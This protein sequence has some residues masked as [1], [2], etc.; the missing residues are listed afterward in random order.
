MKK[1][2]LLCACVI[3]VVSADWQRVIGPSDAPVAPKKEVIKSDTNGL[4]I[5]TEVFGFNTYDTLIDNKTF[6]RVD[7][8]EE[9]FDND[10]IRAGKPQIPYIRLLI[11]VPDSCGFNVSIDPEI[12]GHFGDYLL[13]PIPRIIYEDSGGCICASEVY[14]YDTA[15]YQRDT[16]YP[17][18]F[19]EVK[20]A[21]HWR[22]QRV[23][24]IVLYPVQFNPQTKEMYFYPTMNLRI[25]Y[26]GS[27]SFNTNGLGPFEDMGREVLL[28]YPGIDRS[29]P[30]PPPPAVHYYTYL[31]NPDNVADYIIV[32]HEAFLFN[33]T[34][35][36]WIHDFAQWRVDHNRFDVGI[37]TM[38]DVYEEFLEP[39]YDDSAYA[40]RKFLK[41]AY[42]NWQAYTAL[43]GHFAYSLFIGDWDYVPAKLA[44]YDMG[45][46]DWLGAY[47]GYFRDFDVP[48]DYWD[49]IMLGRWPVKPTSDLVTI[50]QKTINYE[51]YPNIGDWRRRGLL[52]AGDGQGMS[53]F[54][55][56]VSGSRQF[57]SDINYDTMTVRYSQINNPVAF[58]Q[59]IQ[60]NINSGD[61]LTVYYDH[62]APEAWW[63]DFD[64][65]Y[66]KPLKNDGRL[67]VVLSFACL[68]AMFQWDR[69][70][71]TTNPN[72]PPSISIAEHFL[73][74]PNGGSIAFYGSTTFTGG[75]SLFFG[76]VC[77]TRLLRNQYWILGKVVLGGVFAS[78]LSTYNLY[79]YCLLGDPALDL[80]DFTA[81]PTMPDLL[82]RPTGIDVSL[83][84]PHPYITTDDLIPIQVSVWNIGAVTASNIDVKIRVK[85]PLISDTAVITTLNISQIKARDSVTVQYMWDPTIYHLENGVTIVLPDGFVGNAGPA[86]FIFVVDP[87][88]TIN[89]SWEGNNRAKCSK[90]LYFY[91]YDANWPKKMAGA[92]VFGLGNLD[93]TGSVEIVAHDL[94]KVYVFDKN[95]NIMSGWPQDFP[96]V[97]GGVI[98]D[99][100]NDH[101]LD[102]VVVS[103]DSIKAYSYQGN[104]LWRHSL[105]SQPYTP[106]AMPALGKISSSGTMNIIHFVGTTPQAKVMVYD[107][108]G[109]PLYEFN[110]SEYEGVEFKSMGPCISDVN[111][112]GINEIVVSY[113]CKKLDPP[114]AHVY[115]TEVFN[116]IQ[117]TP[118][119]T[120]D[121]G[122]S[123]M[124]PALAD[125]SGD[126]YPEI[127]VGGSDS[128]MHCYKA[129]TGQVL[130]EELTEGPINSSPA[131]GDIH[132]VL[133]G[134]EVAFANNAG[135]QHLL[136]SIN[137]D[138]VDPW[139]YSYGAQPFWL[140]SAPSA[141]IGDINNDRNLDIVIGSNNSQLYGFNYNMTL[142]TPYP[143]PFFGRPGSPFVGDIDGDRKSEVV[144]STAD[145]YL[146][147]LDNRNSSVTI[148]RLEWPQFHHDFQRT[149]LYK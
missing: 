65:L 8:P 52:I 111:G 123:T 62:G 128:K 97:Y 146:H 83:L 136:R 28:N 14:T 32:T 84:D 49:E 76:R 77:L 121:F 70:G 127:F 108:D 135:W 68:T 64:T 21:G 118:L 11:A 107:Y 85:T 113:W 100:N 44:Y 6:Q 71:S 86:A 54:D 41:Y 19:Y 129:T 75:E 27:K 126:L 25:E 103:R 138:R 80:G 35:A 116:R 124:I 42:H 119:I 81:Y 66:V 48:Q 139:P 63:H 120:L 117:A 39:P 36:R 110:A 143:M 130:W 105:Y 148:Y 7:I 96:D 43:D 94:N 4:F 142:I 134:K 29:V 147:A 58:A 78:G 51:K 33:E 72:Y 74:N 132:P 34:T 38:Q 10:T 12:E 24:E 56:L 31:Q 101:Y 5:Q 102:I 30:A 114:R 98:G 122:N 53:D 112:D 109:T 141:A 90:P 18:K 15:F 125:V 79:D 59:K 20:T 45:E 99:I 61:I 57:F 50:A 46:H 17:D 47:E 67:P 149:G 91:P 133:G 104:L 73:L 22:D 55:G 60:H 1:A 106:K 9:A 145:G 92:G 93:G 16:L 131:I 3:T 95:G 89:E 140:E 115:K 40:L 88:N 87:N 82:V 137:G 2:L 13:Y 26:T 144:F 69:P 37:V 23:L